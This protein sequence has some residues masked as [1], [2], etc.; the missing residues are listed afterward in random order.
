MMGTITKQELTPTQHEFIF[1]DNGLFW[2]RKLS[3]DKPDCGVADEAVHILNDGEHGG[4]I[5][6]HTVQDRINSKCGGKVW[7]IDSGMSGAFGDNKKKIHVLEILNDSNPT[8][9]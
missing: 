6:G 4:I 1:G 2:T 5:V 9:I 3:R 8:V 7:R